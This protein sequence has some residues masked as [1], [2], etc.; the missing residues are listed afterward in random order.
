MEASE[1]GVRVCVL[2]QGPAIPEAER[3]AML[4]PFVRG[5]RA[6]NLNEASGFGLGLSIVLAIVEAHNGRLILENRPEGGL[7]AVIEL[8]LAAQA[9]ASRT[10]QPARPL[11]AR[12]A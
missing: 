7:C 8:P 1:R 12:A 11:P 2:D 4:Q 3:D 6:R 9:Y 5:D 10:T